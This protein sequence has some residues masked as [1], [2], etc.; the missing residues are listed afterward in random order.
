MRIRNMEAKIKTVGNTSMKCVVVGNDG[1]GKTS[2]IASYAT[3]SILEE[4]VPTVFDPFNVFDNRGKFIRKGLENSPS[5]SKGIMIR[6]AL[7]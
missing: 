1:T 2:M 5:A 7:H 4:H 6:V 3:G